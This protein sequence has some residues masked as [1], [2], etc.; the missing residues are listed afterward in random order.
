MRRLFNL[1]VYGMC[2]EVGDIK[3]CTEIFSAPVL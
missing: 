1:Y 3:F 2:M